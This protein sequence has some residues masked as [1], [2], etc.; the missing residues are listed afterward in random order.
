MRKLLYLII[1][2]TFCSTVF[3][4]QP[5]KAKR[6]NIFFLKNNGRFVDQ[7]DSADYICII[8]EPDSG[9]TLFIADEFYKDGKRKFSGKSSKSEYLSPEGPCMTYFHNGHKKSY[10]IFKEGK[11]DG[12][13]YYFYPNGKVYV[14]K[15]FHE[16][17]AEGNSISGDESLDY[18]IKDCVDSTGKVL[19]QEGNG[20]FIGYDDN[21]KY[22]EEEGPVKNGVR[23]SIWTGRDN[24][25]T[26]KFT[27]QYQRG[28]LISGVSTDSAGMKYTYMQRMVAPQYRGGVK[29]L[30]D[31][32]GA[33]IK[34]PFY[35]R[36]HD[37]QGTVM[38]GFVIKKDGS[39]KDLKVIKSV[40]SQ[41]DKEAMR[42]MSNSKGWQ[43]G[44]YY[45][46][47]ANIYY[48]LPV[49][50]ALKE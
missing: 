43:P 22:I 37:I 19:V 17:E 32:L 2:I 11:K 8:S 28:K 24:G 36:Q 21:F 45:G 9:S 34:Y 7:K 18:L 49:T 48:T 35:A 44:I 40:D 5:V 3:A 14:S 27:E 42:V 38:L 20:H 41:L 15:E 16:K 31:Y 1:C 50:F 25:A 39:L 33:N 46:K 29:A 23:D 10:E 6:H 26:I 13:C 4:Q 30:Y 47:P 12:L